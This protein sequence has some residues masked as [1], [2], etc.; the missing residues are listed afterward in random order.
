M[1]RRTS[2][3]AISEAR[4][5]NDNGTAP[6]DAAELPD[7]PAP[8]EHAGTGGLYEI[9]DGQRVLVERTAQP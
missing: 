7:T 3:P 5:T 9:R 1:S 8:D 2:G 6:A 4:E